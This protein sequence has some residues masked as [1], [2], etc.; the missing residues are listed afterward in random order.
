MVVYDAVRAVFFA[1]LRVAI[2]QGAS[3]GG[4]SALG[5]AVCGILGKSLGDWPRTH[6]GDAH[7]GAQSILLL[8]SS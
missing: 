4:Y 8:A 7:P 6:R 3:S 5:E 1:D 2:G